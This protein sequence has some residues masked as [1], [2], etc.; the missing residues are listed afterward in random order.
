MLEKFIVLRQ[1]I[2]ERTAEVKGDF[3]G[4]KNRV[5]EL[6]KE[7]IRRQGKCASCEQSIIALSKK[8]DDRIKTGED[9]VKQYK[10]G[11]WKELTIAVTVTGLLVGLAT[12]IIAR[13]V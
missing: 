9:A 7:D 10:E 11:R 13:L 8:L 3:C 5:G 2:K 6:E 12:F 4:L 1:E